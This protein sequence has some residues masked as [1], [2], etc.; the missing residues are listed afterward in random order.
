LRDQPAA[1]VAQQIS[2]TAHANNKMLHTSGTQA[3][4]LVDQDHLALE[5][6]HCNHQ[7]ILSGP[8][9]AA[10]AAYQPTMLPVAQL[11][12]VLDS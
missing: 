11:N 10:M 1:A 9:V 5:T 2:R 3:A 7:Q 6:L 8:M 12:A 4:A